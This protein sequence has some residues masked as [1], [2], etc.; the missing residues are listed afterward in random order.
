MTDE[1]ILVELIDLIV[2]VKI[3]IISNDITITLNLL[4]QIPDC[5]SCS[6]AF[7]IGFKQINFTFS[8]PSVYFAGN[9]LQFKK[10]VHIA[11]ILTFL[12]TQREVIL[13]IAQIFII[14]C[15]NNVKGFFFNLIFLSLWP[16]SERL[17]TWENCLC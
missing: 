16:I 10:C 6:P 15:L 2:S 12:Q 4:S 13:F 1:F 3:L 5:D 14:F 8:N 11:A 17:L 9:F 7:W